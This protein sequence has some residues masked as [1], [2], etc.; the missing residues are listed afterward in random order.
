MSC[1]LT[2]R[3]TH[4]FFTCC[5]ATHVAK[6]FFLTKKTLFRKDNYKYLFF[7]TSWYDDDAVWSVHLDS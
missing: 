4:E 6:H 7:F 2:F 3:T 1:L 5:L